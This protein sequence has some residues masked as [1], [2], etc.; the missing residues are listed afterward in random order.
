MQRRLLAPAI[1]AVDDVIMTKQKRVKKLPR[2]GQI[3]KCRRQFSD[4]RFANVQIRPRAQLWPHALATRQDIR[5]NH[6][7]E[8]R[9]PRRIQNASQQ[10]LK[11]QLNL[12]EMCVREKLQMVPW[13][14]SKRI[15]SANPYPLQ[16]LSQDF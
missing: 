4:P 14:D 12:R 2:P 15:V 7:I 9:Q 10:A 16:G 1:G 8:R 13:P 6:L 3:Q 11:M 5:T